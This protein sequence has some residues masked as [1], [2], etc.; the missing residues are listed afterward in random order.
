MHAW[1]KSGFLT[2]EKARIDITSLGSESI[3]DGES[4]V[5]KRKI[6]SPPLPEDTD[7]L[8]IKKLEEKIKNLERSIQQE[9]TESLKK[10]EPVKNGKNDDT[11][12]RQARTIERKMKNIILKFYPKLWS[13]DPK[14]SKDCVSNWTNVEILKYLDDW[15]L[16]HKR[17][18][19]NQL[20]AQLDKN[21]LR[22]KIEI[23]GEIFSTCLD[24]DALTETEKILSITEYLTALKTQSKLTL[25]KLSNY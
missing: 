19:S 3:S 16:Q 25:R 14:L 21:T 9:N 8:I 6:M 18:L 13:N 4:S 5:K 17:D 23:A 15:V 12:E 20:C 11:P 10:S 24:K 1:K 2:L 7:E 22:A